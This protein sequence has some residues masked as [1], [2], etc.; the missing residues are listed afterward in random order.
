[1]SIA[2]HV[3]EQAHA[4]N[5]A[6]LAANFYVMSHAD[7]HLQ[8]VLILHVSPWAGADHRVLLQA[9]WNP[10]NDFETTPKD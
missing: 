3:L 4:E 1:M 2:V 5:R 10:C 7:L 8:Q 6:S 9:L